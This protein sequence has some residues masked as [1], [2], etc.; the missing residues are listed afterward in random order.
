M[1]SKGKGVWVGDTYW[2][3]GVLKHTKEK[4]IEGNPVKNV[5]PITV[6]EYKDK[7]KDVYKVFENEKA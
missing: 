1:N 2:S 4:N 3:F 6:D 5:V 7:W